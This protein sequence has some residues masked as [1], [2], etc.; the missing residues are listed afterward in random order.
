VKSEI[1][2][3]AVLLVVA[4]AGRTTRFAEESLN[5]RACHG[6]RGLGKDVQPPVKTSGE[7][8]LQ[9]DSPIAPCWAR[10][11]KNPGPSIGWDYKFLP[12]VT[13]SNGRE[14][15]REAGW[16]GESRGF[17]Q[18][19]TSVSGPMQFSPSGQYSEAIARV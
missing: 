4:G 2:G 5:G 14:R 10:G 17:D 11:I 1:V 13:Q 6:R 16:L 15:A 19:A 12:L 9:S 8:C 18:P 7:D 3:L